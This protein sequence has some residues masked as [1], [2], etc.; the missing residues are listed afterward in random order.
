[1]KASVLALLVALVAG[2]CASLSNEKD[3]TA[4]WSAQRLYGEAKDEMTSRN[5]EKA[6]KYLEKLEARYPYGRYAQQAQLDV[7][8]AYWKSGERAS[9]VAAAD[10]FIKLYPNH[11][12]VDYAW[13]L[14]GL[15][16]FNENQGIFGVFD[17][18]DMTERDPKGSYSAFES[19]KEVV[20]RFPESKYAEDAAAR[21][22]F[23]VNSLAQNEVHVARYYMK[24]GAYVA[25]ANRA[26][27]AVQN[28]P[29]APAIEEAVFIMVKAY[30]ALGM[31]D[32]RNAADRVM[33]KNFPDSK[34]LNPKGYKR[35]VPWWKLWDPDW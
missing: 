26:Q 14:K 6:I 15:V 29:N 5:W 27:Y 17:N 32:L 30:D 20:T 33:R 4:G 28:Y 3:E 18:P 31:D 35:D 7:A 23:L 8:Y 22:R 10:R 34:Y 12:N 24:R 21:M 13:Y 19:F 11:T 16:N 9:A 1:M 2:G 25:A